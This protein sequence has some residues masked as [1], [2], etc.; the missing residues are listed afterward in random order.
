M[1]LLDVAV[2]EKWIDG[3]LDC[4]NEEYKMGIQNKAAQ[5]DRENVLQG[6]QIQLIRLQDAIKSG[7]LDL[8][9]N[10]IPYA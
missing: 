1:K 6:R 4:I 5:R 7:I 9:Q 10:P 3:Q 8:K 2:L